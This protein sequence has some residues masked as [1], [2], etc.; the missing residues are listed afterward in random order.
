MY[1]DNL[2]ETVIS[3]LE[4]KQVIISNIITNLVSQGYLINNKK[5]VKLELTSL[6]IDAFEN[7]NIFTD[8]QQTNIEQI[9]NKVF[10]YE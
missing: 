6:L 9:Y 1:N 4:N 5:K 7:I 8:E 10:V 2:Q 3:D